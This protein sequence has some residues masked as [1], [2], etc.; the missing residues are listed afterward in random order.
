MKKLIMENK[1]LCMSCLSCELACA[2]AFYKAPVSEYACTQ[3]N[4]KDDGTIKPSLCVQCGKCAR[5]CEAGAITQNKKGTYILNKKLCVGCL[6]CVD[7][8]PFGLIVK[9]DNVEKPSKCIACGICVKACP[10]D[11]LKVVES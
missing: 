8:C 3:I 5:A 11:I 10:V 9:A 4:K 1:E 2:E 6:K 7:V